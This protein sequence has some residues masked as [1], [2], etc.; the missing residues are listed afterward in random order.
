MHILKIILS[1][2]MVVSV[3]SYAGLMA[4]SAQD[5]R[6]QQIT[7]S[8][9]SSNPTVATLTDAKKKLQGGA[10]L[11]LKGKQLMTLKN[12]GFKINKDME[13]H[14]QT[15]P[16]MTYQTQVRPGSKTELM[17]NPQTSTTKLQP[18]QP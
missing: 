8:T 18:S 9:D 4:D 12:A 2:L 5:V 15:N 17:V 11:T 14:A 7:S 13:K 10:V 1:F 16:E 6:L 3:G